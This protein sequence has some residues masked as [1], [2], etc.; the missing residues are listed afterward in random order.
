MKNILIIFLLSLISVTI[1][2][3]TF[4]SGNFKFE[5]LNSEKPEVKIT[6][7]LQSGSGDLNIPSTV[8]YD[9]QQYTVVSIA[10]NAF[11]RCNGYSSLTIPNT[12]Q[13]IGKRAFDHCTSLRGK[14]VIPNSVSYIGEYAFQGC[15]GFDS[16]SL[17]STLTRIK[18]RV[19]FDCSGFSGRLTI[20]NSVLYI[21]D[22][23]FEGCSGFSEL[24][25]GTSV[26]VIGTNAFLWC[27]LKGELVI[28]NSVISIGARAFE[29]NKITSLKLSDSLTS[30]EK[31]AFKDCHNLTGD[32]VIPRSVTQIGERAFS[33]TDIKTLTF[34]SSPVLSINAF[35]NSHKLQEVKC[36]SDISPKPIENKSMAQIF[37]D[38]NK[39]ILLIP[40]GCLKAYADW[41]WLGCDIFEELPAV[42]NTNITTESDKKVGNTISPTGNSVK[43]TTQSDITPVTHAPTVIDDSPIYASPDE[44]AQFPGGDLVLEKFISKSIKYPEN[45][46]SNRVEGTIILKCVVERNG[47]I[48]NTTVEKGGNT[49]L[50]EEAKRVVTKLPRWIPGKHNGESVRSYVIISVPFK[51]NS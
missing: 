35:G 2:G 50:E 1:Q 41:R 38:S 43:P 25:L 46:Y 47:S 14:L 40:K 28:P 11:N 42:K 8:E 34:E 23:A 4:R 36:Y 5:V 31:F 32:I 9:N 51:I 24:V 20:P 22:E 49:D 30:I 15:S 10:D 13:I 3:Q 33:W 12:I 27:K 37:E 48:T 26:K 44:I 16:L 7:A 18:E 6:G 17:P 21:E 45:A 29:S 19:F 39:F